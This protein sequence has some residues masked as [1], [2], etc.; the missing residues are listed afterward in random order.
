M[1]F[2]KHISSS[3][4]QAGNLYF[5]FR[6]RRDEHEVQTFERNGNVIVLSDCWMQRVL[7]PR[8]AP[9]PAARR[10][11]DLVIQWVHLG[12]WSQH[13]LDFR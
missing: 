3:T 9:P 13:D 7:A 5:S 11:R 8:A 12:P 4:Q 1:L 10:P 6:P 2:T